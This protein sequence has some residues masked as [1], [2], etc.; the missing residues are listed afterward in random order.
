MSKGVKYTF[1]V[2]LKSI[3]QKIMDNSSNDVIDWDNKA[4]DETIKFIENIPYNKGVN[5][6]YYL[7][8]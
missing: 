3:L 4:K 2:D 6:Q 8:Y 5:H 1:S 7:D